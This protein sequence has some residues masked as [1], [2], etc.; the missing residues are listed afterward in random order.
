MRGV[1][2]DFQKSLA[3]AVIVALTISGTLTLASTARIAGHLL[4]G[5]TNTYDVGST[6]LTWRSGFFGTSVSSTEVIAGGGT[7][8]A[9]SISFSG[10]S[11]TGLYQFAANS[12]A[13]VAGGAVSAYFEAG[14]IYARGSY[15]T[16]AEG[17]GFYF[18]DAVRGLRFLNGDDFEFQNWHVGGQ[19][20]ITSYN[21]TV[22]TRHAVFDAPTKRA[23]FSDTTDLRN[24]TPTTTLEVIGLGTSSSKMFVGGGANQYTI[25]SVQSAVINGGGTT[26]THQIGSSTNKS[27]LVL[28]D[29]DGAGVTYVTALDG[30]LTASMTACNP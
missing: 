23:A 2:A 19:F 13:I 7:L 16:L 24:V 11:D 20:Y 21:G 1:F 18:A 3:N 17:D 22:R 14:K 29:I 27:C 15:A 26:S 8:G 5:T 28:G 10:D 12:P 4:P 9:P 25:G 6:S 30:V